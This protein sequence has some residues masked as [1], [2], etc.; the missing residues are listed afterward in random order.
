MK[1]YFHKIIAFIWF[2]LFLWYI[3]RTIRHKAKY[4]IDSYN[5]P[6]RGVVA[7]GF[8]RDIIL[9]RVPN[10]MDVFFS[11]KKEM[12]FIAYPRQKM[13]LTHQLE[14]LTV[15]TLFAPTV[16]VQYIHND[17]LDNSGK[18]IFLD[19]FDFTINA[20]GYCLNSGRFNPDFDS[21]VKDVLNKHLIS[22]GNYRVI[23][24]LRYN[25]LLKYGFK[26]PKNRPLNDITIDAISD[27]EFETTGE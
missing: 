25:K 14:Y 2:P 3:K 17:R 26:I 15:Y 24:E 16:S 13:L 10:D 12:N 20:L 8:L 18:F 6:Y 19:N 23:T 5:L 21:R 22:L 7:G 11:D 27:Y 4:L 9:G 1:Y